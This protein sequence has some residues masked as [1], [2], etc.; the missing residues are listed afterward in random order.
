MEKTSL[1]VYKI[2]EVKS[3]LITFLWEITAVKTVIFFCLS[4]GAVRKLASLSVFL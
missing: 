4:E 1:S 2:L 3:Y